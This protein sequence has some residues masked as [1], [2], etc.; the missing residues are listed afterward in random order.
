MPRVFISHASG[1]RQQVENCII[2][3]LEDIGVSTWF[4]PDDISAASEWQASILAGL[5]ECDWF[6]VALSPRSIDSEW[7]KTEV[8]LAFR[9]FP[10]DRILPVV[11]EACDSERCDLRLVRRQHIDFP[12]DENATRKLQR[13]FQ[14]ASQ[15]EDESAESDDALELVGRLR[16]IRTRGDTS[17]VPL[18]FRCLRHANVGVQ[19]RARHYMKWA[20]NALFIK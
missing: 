5:K 11:L 17:Q 4:S 13:V 15:D 18:V 10:I 9:A 3:P 19:N 20:G 12:T 8:Q 6:L 14:C 1:D 16:S 7:V 2:Q